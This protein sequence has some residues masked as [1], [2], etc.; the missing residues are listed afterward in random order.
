MRGGKEHEISV[1]DLQVGD[2]LRLEVGDEIPADAVIIQAVDFKVDESA[3]TGESDAIDKRSEEECWK[4]IR[5]TEISRQQCQNE[6]E[7]TKYV[8]TT[9]VG[10]GGIPQHQIVASP[11]LIGG[12]T[13]IAG[14]CSAIVI[15]VGV[16]AQQGRL[17]QSLNAV[18]A[19]PTPLQS[20]PCTRIIN[21]A[22][23]L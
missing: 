8:K 5:E 7:A 15:A 18:D 1:F 2:V 12:S 20:R 17:F 11:V 14:S 22:R 6:D 3:M 21:Q 19:D 4:Q 10:F 9:S 13:T 16:R 23:T